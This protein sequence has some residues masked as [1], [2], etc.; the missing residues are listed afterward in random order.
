MIRPLL[1]YEAGL[2]DDIATG[3]SMRVHELLGGA[4]RFFDFHELRWAHRGYKRFHRRTLHV[5]SYREWDWYYYKRL[6]DFWA[7]AKRLP[8]YSGVPPQNAIRFIFLWWYKRYIICLIPYHARRYARTRPA[9]LARLI[10]FIASRRSA[11]PIYLFLLASIASLTWWYTLMI[12]IFPPFPLFMRCFYEGIL[13]RYYNFSGL[14]PGAL[15]LR[16]FH[17]ALPRQ[18]H[19]KASWE[20]IM[21][22]KEMLWVARILISYRWEVYWKTMPLRELHAHYHY[23]RRLTKMALW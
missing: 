5:K 6:P 12:S 11:S 23:E 22:K 17:E 14:P 19:A 13:F 2:I 4:A 3:L 1:F 15:S 10:I 7:N 9:S 16:H 8:I 21:K 20:W 18:F